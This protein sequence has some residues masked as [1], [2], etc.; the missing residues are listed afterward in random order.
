MLSSNIDISSSKTIHSYLKQRIACSLEFESVDASLVNK[1]IDNLTA[2][3]VV[4]RMVVPPF[5]Q[6]RM[7]NVL[8]DPL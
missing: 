3:T 7:K 2:K 5:F 4:D 1:N 6:K 8:V